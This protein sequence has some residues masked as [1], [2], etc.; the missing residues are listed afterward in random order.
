VW[1]RCVN[2]RNKKKKCQIGDYRRHCNVFLAVTGISIC[3]S[4]QSR[5]SENARAQNVEG[6]GGTT[7]SFHANSLQFPFPRVLSMTTHSRSQVVVNP[8]CCPLSLSAL[9]K[10]GT[11]REKNQKAKIGGK[12]FRQWVPAAATTGREEKNGLFLRTRA[13]RG[14]VGK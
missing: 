1:S 9:L 4:D 6:Q 12:Q 14:C 8:F 13:A 10:I 3:G 7:N 5:E 11:T 2:E